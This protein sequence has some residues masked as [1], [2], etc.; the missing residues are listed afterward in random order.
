[1][2]QS[3]I[4]KYKDRITVGTKDFINITWIEQTEKKLGFPLPDSYKEMLLNY[5]FITIC[6][7]D[8]K[9]IAPPEYQE[10]ADIDIYYTY[11]INLQNNLFQKDELAFL[12]MDEE[13][14]FF[15]IEEAG[16]ANEY[17]VYIRDYMMNEDHLYANNFQE[18][19]EHFFSILLGND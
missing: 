19:L 11:L 7:V 14:Y 1:M 12:E 18:F 4:E 10:D 17:P 3:I 5:E 13:A 9:T 15:K 16:Q 8:F 6:G 2:I